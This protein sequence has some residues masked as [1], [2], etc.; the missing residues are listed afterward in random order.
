[1][2]SLKA[3]LLCK[4]PCLHDVTQQEVQVLAAPSMH[5]ETSMQQLPA[6]L[7]VAVDAGMGMCSCGR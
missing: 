1:M 6:V 2:G 5:E 7:N 4:P 3:A